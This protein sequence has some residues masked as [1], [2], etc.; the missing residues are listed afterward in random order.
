MGK[1]SQRYGNSKL[2]AGSYLVRREQRYSSFKLA[3]ARNSNPLAT[4]WYGKGGKGKSEFQEK[5]SGILA[6]SRGLAL[7]NARENTSPQVLLSSEDNGGA[8]S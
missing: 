8:N 1:G 4:K 7:P 6:A 2:A 3:T 5:F